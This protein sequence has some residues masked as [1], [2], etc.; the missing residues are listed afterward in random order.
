MLSDLQ[1]RLFAAKHDAL[2]VVLQA[3]DTGGKDGVLR[4]VVHRDQP[5]GRRRQLVRGPVGGGAVT[6]LPLARASPLPC[7]GRDRD[8]QP[9]PLRRC[10]GRA[11][12]AARACRA[13]EAAVRR[14]RRLRTD[15]HRRGHAHREAV[16]QHLE[17]GAAPAAPGP[18]RHPREALEVPPR[19]PR[20][21]GAVGRL[22]A[23]PTPTRWPRRRPRRRRGTWCPPTGSGCATSPSRRSCAMCSSASIRSSPSRRTTSTG[24]SS[25]NA[26]RATHDRGLTFCTVAADAGR[27]P[28]HVARSNRRPRRASR[29]DGARRRDR[30]VGRDQRG[31]PQHRDGR[32][33]AGRRRRRPCRRAAVVD[34]RSGC[35][36]D[37]DRRGYHVRRAD[38]RAAG[39]AA[40]GARRG[41]T[42]GR[43]TTDPDRRH[44]RGQP[45]HLLA[46]RRRAARAV[47]ARRR[48]IELTGPSGDRTM[49]VHD[50]M[51]GVK[52]TALER[53]RADHRRHVAAARRLA[54]LLE[55]RRAQRDGD[56]HRQRL[57][58]R[59]RRRPVRCGWRSAPS[60]RRSSVPPRRKRSRPA[61]STGTAT[62][63]IRRRRAPLRRTGGRRQ[64]ADR[65]PPFHGGVPPPRDR[66][67]GDP[68]AAAGVP[69]RTARERAVHAARQR[70]R[71]RRHRRL[72]RR[73]PALRAARA[74]RAAGRQGGV[75]A[76]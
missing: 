76:G 46:G 4:V 9:Q 65:R 6:R 20:R 47:G 74:A 7:E 29:R 66:C 72:A 75:R 60:A 69:G 27:R 33:V 52:R 8:L 56:R 37:H 40:A 18:D 17:G 57:S 15:A 39:D 35:A 50:F 38:G 61:P 12:Q 34:D 41:V 31:A 5:G 10:P 16:P 59:R 43:V 48:S 23:R 62:P 13:L 63:V 26:D 49:S 28:A 2:L 19:R 32:G 1:T 30:C 51:V 64:P 58:R 73:E 24:W 11:R 3:M 54:G 45:R 68:P 25:S 71:P 22:H 36:H 21:P 42:H 14:D 67:H 44:A 55:G 53:G 70:R